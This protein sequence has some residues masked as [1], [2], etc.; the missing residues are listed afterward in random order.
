MI[1]GKFSRNNR[2]LYEP[3]FFLAVR[4]L[5]NLHLLL[6]FPEHFT[7]KNYII[8]EK[9]SYQYTFLI[10]N[11]CNFSGRSKILQRCAKIYDIEILWENNYN[12]IKMYSLCGYYYYFLLAWFL[13]MKLLCELCSISSANTS[14]IYPVFGYVY[15]SLKNIHHLVPF[16][17]ASFYGWN[18]LPS[19]PIFFYVYFDIV[20]E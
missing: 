2:G 13:T 11:I 18:S 6:I 1:L 8:K 10:S 19:G 9:S 5:V 16:F 20:S 15:V 7:N 4:H 12:V 14:D 17:S 3:R